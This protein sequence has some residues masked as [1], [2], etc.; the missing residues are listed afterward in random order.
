MKEILK[1]GNITIIKLYE[2]RFYDGSQMKPLWALREFNLLGD[3]IVIFR[4]GMNVKTEEMIDQLDLIKGEKISGKDL[5][6]VVV[7]HFDIQPPNIE[8]AYLRQRLLVNLFHEALYKYGVERR[9]SDLY[10]KRKKLSVSIASISNISMKIH[11]AIN[12][13]CED[14]P[15]E[16]SCLENFYRNDPLNLARDVCIKYAEELE[17]IK[18]DIYK[19]KE[20]KF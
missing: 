8:I 4:G 18:K 15:I 7:E 2:E 3:S 9:F 5:V 11:F 16:I 20:I 1:A 10:Y 17:K 14:A 12:I 13:K 19:T 6:H